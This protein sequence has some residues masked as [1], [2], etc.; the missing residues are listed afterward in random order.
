MSKATSTKEKLK[1]KAYLPSC[2][3]VYYEV[4]E[5][6]SGFGVA[7]KDPES[8][9]TVFY[10][11]DITRSRSDVESFVALCNRLGLSRIHFLDAVDDFIG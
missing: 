10:V 1:D 7:V 8:N 4:T 2:S 3:S 11:E 9:K 6:G 5:N